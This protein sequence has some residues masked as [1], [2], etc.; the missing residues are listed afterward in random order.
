TWHKARI[1]SA[2]NT[3]VTAD[4]RSRSVSRDAVLACQ[5]LPATKILHY[6]A[7]E[8]STAHVRRYGAVH[9]QQSRQLA[10]PGN[11]NQGTVQHID[12]VFGRAGRREYTDPNINIV[13]WHR[14][15]R[16]WQLW[17]CLVLTRSRGGY[18]SHLAGGQ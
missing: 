11:F 18:Q 13:A 12:Q 1:E 7:G 14:L 6:T 8:L 3:C 15:G 17:K 2:G 9:I 4:F 16:G 5:C 10:G